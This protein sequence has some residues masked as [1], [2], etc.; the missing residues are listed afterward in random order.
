[1]NKPI[2]L[3]SSSNLSSDIDSLYHLRGYASVLNLEDDVSDDEV[4]NYHQ[5]NIIICNSMDE[6][7][8][9]KL[10]FIAKDTVHRVCV[11]RKYES[12]AEPWVVKAHADFAIKDTS[13][14]KK[15]ANVVEVLTYIMHLDHF[16]KP[17]GNAWFYLK[18]IKALFGCLLSCH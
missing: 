6:K 10:R 11:L 7:Q 14:L 2:L 17:D 13:F 12:T 4:K 9:S 8:F 1:M 18:K 5:K 3:L 16:K 15:C